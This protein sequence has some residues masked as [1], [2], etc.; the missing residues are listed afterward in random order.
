M[1]QEL[2]KREKRNQLILKVV[3]LGVIAMFVLGI[4]AS[5]VAQTG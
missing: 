2:T 3:I 4:F 1:A 5:L